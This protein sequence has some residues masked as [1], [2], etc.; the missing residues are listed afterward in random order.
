MM[1]LKSKFWVDLAQI[2]EDIIEMLHHF[3]NILQIDSVGE[4]K[5]V[6]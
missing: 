5:S 6:H 1:N 4:K 3:N 2:S